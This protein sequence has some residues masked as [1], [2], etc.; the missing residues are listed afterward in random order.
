MLL[1]SLMPNWGI[2]AMVNS[3][4]SGTCGSVVVVVV[5]CWYSGVVLPWCGKEEGLL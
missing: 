3:L 5:V 4:G 2:L 1:N